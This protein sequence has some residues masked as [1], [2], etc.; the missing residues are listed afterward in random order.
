[1]R[2]EGRKQTQL[3]N[4]LPMLGKT[5]PSERS[6]SLSRN[7]LPPLP[8]IKSRDSIHHLT[9]VWRFA[10]RSGTFRS[11]NIPAV[12]SIAL[13]ESDFSII[14]RLLGLQAGFATWPQ[15]PQT[16][17][18]VNDT[19]NSSQVTVVQSDYQGLSQRFIEVVR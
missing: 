2:P 12:F 10:S 11:G 9:I 18:A 1:M 16:S 17:S 14:R 13:R 4:Q 3:P 7:L 8:R 15:S 5:L 6:N 19:S